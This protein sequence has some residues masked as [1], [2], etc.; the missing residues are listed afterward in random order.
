MSAIR[1]SD[2][3]YDEIANRLDIIKKVDN[4]NISFSGFEYEEYSAV[5]ESMIKFK[6]DIPI[7][8]KR[9]IIREGIRNSGLSGKI[10]EGS[11]LKYIS[12]S[13]NEYL[14]K[15]NRPYILSTY[16]NI[17]N[18]LK[19]QNISLPEAYITFSS[20][21]PQKYRLERDK[22]ENLSKKIITYCTPSNSIAVRVR[23]NAKDEYEAANRALDNIDY[24]RSIINFV[25]TSRFR[26]SFGGSP[27]PVNEIFLGPVH[28]LHYPNG[29]RASETFWYQKDYVSTT[30]IRLNNKIDDLKI[31]LRYIR[32]K[33]KNLGYFNENKD[34]LLTYVRALD[35]PDYNTAFIFLWGILERLTYTKNLPY[36]FTIKRAASLFEEYNYHLQVLNHLREYRNSVIHS[37]KAYNDI[38]PY[39]FQLK[40][41]I[42]QLFMFLIV[43]RFSFNSI[44]DAAVLSYS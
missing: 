23:V 34:L 39:I 27:K 36:K 25:I 8:M 40:R 37:G 2:F 6:E 42:D 44:Q 41:Y 18:S 3:K 22:L 31:E 28:I 4:G 26:L 19:L 38:E 21:L 43:N 12:I 14:S 13:E 11:L 15:F 1:N 29:R 5:L 20:Y 9:K 35:Y 17:H 16:L 30:A 10:T 7:F 33:L 24:I 32:N